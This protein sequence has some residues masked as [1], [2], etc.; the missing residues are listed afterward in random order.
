V[1]L[2]HMAV[3]CSSPSGQ[4]ATYPYSVRL[5]APGTKPSYSTTGTGPGRITSSVYTSL[6]RLVVVLLLSGWFAECMPD[7]MWQGMHHII[8]KV[9]CKQNPTAIGPYASEQHAPIDMCVCNVLQ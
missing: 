4:P 2:G 5:P 6:S 1:G 7:A 9:L 8:K 3:Y